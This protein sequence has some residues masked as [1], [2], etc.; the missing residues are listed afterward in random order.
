MTSVRTLLP[1][2]AA[3]AGVLVALGVSVASVRPSEDGSATEDPVLFVPAAPVTGAGVLLPPEG[4]GTRAITAEEIEA[5]DQGSGRTGVQP[6]SMAFAGIV[7]RLRTDFPDDFGM[8]R[9]NPD[10]RSASVSFVGDIPAE[11]PAL[12]QELGGVELHGGYGVRE[13]EYQDAAAD[14]FQ[15]LFERNAAEASFQTYAEPDRRVIVVE[16]GPVRVGETVSEESRRKIA[17]DA[18][19]VVLPERFTLEFAPKEHPV[20]IVAESD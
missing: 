11:V 19:A 15:L 18:R 4:T 2:I 16:F 14:L 17:E 7:D 10:L 12:F 5:M 9:L 8:S 3:T 20:F 6:W 13:R 1:A